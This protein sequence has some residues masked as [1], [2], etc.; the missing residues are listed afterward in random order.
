[1]RPVL[2]LLLLA[3][4]SA[5]RLPASEPVW[6]RDDSGLPGY[7]IP[8]GLAVGPDQTIYLSLYREDGVVVRRPGEGWHVASDLRGVAAY[9]VA[10]GPPSVALAATV[11]GVYRTDDGGRSWRRVS[12]RQP[13]YAVHFDRDGAAW[14]GGEGEILRSSD[15]GKSWSVAAR[16]D[17]LVTVLGLA[18]GRAGLVVATAGGGLRL[19]RDDGLHQ[20]LSTRQVVSS[21]AADRE[22]R[23]AA[24]IEGRLWISVSGE[25]WEP[26]GSFDRPV[27]AVGAAD[28]ALLA[29]T[30]GAGVYRSQDGGARWTLVGG[31]LSA[32]VYA[33]GGGE[34][35]W[36]ATAHG[37]LAAGVEGWETTGERVGRPLVR[38]MAAAGALLAATSDGVYQREADGW[39]PLGRDL[40]GVLT[41]FVLPAG[42]TLV[43]GTF[44]RGILRSTDG[45]RSWETVTEAEYARAIVPSIAAG[46]DTLV[47]RVEYD[48]TLQSRDR[49]ESWALADAGLAGR[50]VFAVATDGQ[51]FWAG[52]DAGVY[53]F[54]ESVWRALPPLAGTVSALLAT[55]EGLVAGTSDGLWRLGQGSWG[56][57][58]LDG[59]HVVAL[60]AGADGRLEI[61]G[62]S[63]DG[64]FRRDGAGWRAFGLTGERINALA[65]DPRDGALVVATESGVWRTR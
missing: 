16:F 4:L 52:T 22:G 49:G 38:G 36:A 2:A 44:E 50:T 1:M 51:A 62:T 24:R 9:G 30:E 32:T 19:W 35:V 31:P 6:T 7:A 53:R 3:L 18:R 41:L 27:V 14:A 8:T 58:G 65:R 5:C 26:A 39:R 43:A 15:G 33:V 60:L 12:A 11:D 63:S 29:A 28:D 61:A 47:A 45:G 46:G 10:A 57:F 56:R 42:G 64:L 25:T 23:L 40:R 59:R 37:V 21:V 20:T 17:S 54:E 34:R 48:R 13:I 55:N